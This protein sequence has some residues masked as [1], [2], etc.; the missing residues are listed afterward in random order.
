[1]VLFSF[2]SLAVYSQVEVKGK[3][4]DNDRAAVSDVTVRAANAVTATNA[5]GDF[6]IRASAGDTLYF[7]KVGLQSQQFLYTGQ[8]SINI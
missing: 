2:C 6:T 1:M 3:V 5:S 4:T 7:D 8:S